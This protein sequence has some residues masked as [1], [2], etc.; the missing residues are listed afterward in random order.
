VSSRAFASGA[1]FQRRARARETGIS[2]APSTTKPYWACPQGLCDAIVEPSATK[3]S[4]RWALRAGGPLLE[5]G[6]EK[7]GY[8]PADLQSAYKV[9][10]IG[11]A[12]QTIALVDAY[13][14]K[15]AE[16]DLAKYRERY[17]LEPCT[18]ANGCFGKVNQKGEEANYPGAQKGWEGETSLDLDMASAAC[19]RCHI[20]LVQATESSFADLGEAVNTAARLGATEISNSY[21]AAEESCGATHCEEYAADYHHAGTVVIASSG[22]SGYDNHYE[23]SASPSFPA[24]LPFVVAVGGTGLHKS[25]GSRGWSEEVWNEPARELGSGS[26]CSLSEPKPAWQTDSGCTK[27]TDNDIAAVAACTTPVSI[28]STAYAG[29]E[30]FCGTS[31]SAPFVAG[32]E[33]HAGERTRSLGPQAFYEDRATLFGVTK[34]SNGTCSVAYLCSAETQDA[35]YDGPVGV[36]TPDGIPSAPPTITG[37]APRSG[38][39]AGGTQVTISGTNLT[40]ATAVKFGQMNATSFTV[41]SEGSLTAVAPPGAGTVQVAVEGAAGAGPVGPGAEFTY[42]PTYSLGIEAEWLED[43]PTDVAANSEGDIWISSWETG[44]VRELKETGEP[45]RSI[46]GLE[47]PCSGSLEGPYGLAVDSTGDL[48]VS[49]LLD[50]YIRKF[51]AE[52]KCLLQVYVGGAPRGIAVDAHGNVWVSG[53]GSGCVQELSGEGVSERKVGCELG[54]AHAFP[55]GLA[56]DSRGHIWLADIANSRVIKLGEAG[57]YLG[58]IGSTTGCGPVLCVPLAVA[59]DASGNILVSSASRIDEFSEAGEL[60]NQVGGFGSREGQMEFPM[61]LA[62]DSKGSLWVAD[63]GNGRIEKWG[64][65]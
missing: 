47:A 27:R 46:G 62:V 49:D 11:G 16:S 59:T 42:A 19:P 65:G 50:G 5:G 28:Y 8:D 15:T 13:G 9:S 26:G 40:E 54:G 51:S 14:D 64:G 6:G 58:Q 39:A 48:W 12:K 4:G 41:S 45:L 2:L 31:V 63:T 17:G 57:E 30:N 10:P 35:G 22:D 29:W 53:T 25:T 43:P 20:L 33:A 55:G 7:G 61:G 60:L 3:T 21:G 34:G 23:A 44:T 56:V 24:T 32:I 52:G 36:G 38:P 1:R 18:K 37:I